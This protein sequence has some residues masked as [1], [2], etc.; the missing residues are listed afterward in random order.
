MFA[1]RRFFARVATI[2]VFVAIAIGIAAAPA[3]A[4]TPTHAHL[5]I[6]SAGSGY[7]K[8][9]VSGVF[10]MS[11]ADAQ[12]FIY[13]I[14]NGGMEYRIMGF[15]FS[16]HDRRFTYYGGPAMPGTHAGGW[17]YAGT[18]GIHFYR[19][20]VVSNSVLN[21]D[22]GWTDGPGDEIFVNARFV[23]GDGG[24][25]AVDSNQVKGRW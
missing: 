14:G 3:M 9:A 2:G 17:L 23:D 13:N 18:E 8:V 15:D 5:S 1:V 22:T 12:G 19:E 7:S 20:V 25:R 4:A 24:V 11:Q 21:E 16:G 10:A 6:T